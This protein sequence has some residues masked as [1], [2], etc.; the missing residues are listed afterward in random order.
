MDLIIE[1]LNKVILTVITNDGEYEITLT[2][3]QSCV[4]KP[5]MQFSKEDC[6]KKASIH[7]PFDDMILRKVNSEVI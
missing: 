6:F 5:T 1:Q 3:D 7:M 2:V 4:D